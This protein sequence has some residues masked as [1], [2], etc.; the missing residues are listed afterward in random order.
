[1]ICSYEG[2]ELLSPL[3]YPHCKLPSASYSR[4]I[5]LLT[6]GEVSNED[7]V[8]D[9]CRSM[10]TS[11]RIFSFGLGHSPSRSVIK[12]LARTTNGF[13]VFIPPNAPVDI[14]VAQQ[15]E[16]AL[17]PCITN[18]QVKWNQTDIETAPTKV[19]PVYANDRLIFYGLLNTISSR[20]EHD[21]TVSFYKTDN[22]I[23][24]GQAEMNYI[25][26]VV[27]DQTI[28][29]LAAKAFIN[30]LQHANTAEQTRFN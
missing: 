13:S 22:N 17:Q 12:G 27:G 23:L 5:F 30:E 9:L 25:S 24:L 7:E 1:M 8:L 11:S 20:F 28:N 6:D 19:P 4:Q 29:R 16:K 21:I 15:L 2:T 3:Q 10:S 18:V 26:S 14:Y